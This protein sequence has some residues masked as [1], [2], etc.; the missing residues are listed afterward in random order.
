MCV[1]VQIYKNN[2]FNFTHIQRLAVSIWII[3]SLASLGENCKY[4]CTSNLPVWLQRRAC[5]S[6]GLVTRVAIKLYIKRTLNILRGYAGCS[7]HL[8]FP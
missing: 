8:V 5:A 6:M 4:T 7:V 2:N 3:N 1:L